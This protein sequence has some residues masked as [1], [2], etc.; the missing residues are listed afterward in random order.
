MI[1]V[2]GLTRKYGS[3]VAVDDISFICKPGTVTGFLGPNGAGKTTTMRVMVGLTPATAGEVTIGGLHF[4]DIPNPGRHVGRPPRRLGPA[5]RPH[6]PRGA[7]PRRQ[8][9]GPADVAGRR[10]ARPGLAR[11]H[12]GQ[13]PGPQLLPRHAAAARHR[14]RP[15]RRPVGAD[16]RR[17]R[18]RPRPGRHPLD[19]RPPQGLLRPRRHRAALQPPAQRGRADRRRDAADRPRQDR[20]PRHQGRAARGRRRD[21]RPGGG[22]GQRRPDRRPHGERGWPTRRSAWASGS[23]P[24]RST[25]AGSSVENRPSCSPTCAR[26]RAVS[27]TSSSSSPPTPSATTSS[28]RPP[29]Q[30]PRCDH[31]RCAHDPRRQPDRPGAVQPA[32]PGRA[33]QD[34]RHPG[35]PLA[36]DLDRGVHRAGAGHPAVGGARPGPDGHASTTSRAARTSR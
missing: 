34:V 12:R 29:R 8:D 36:A 22:R 21:R 4:H 27:R 2:E 24:C 14:P 23:T 30:E 18:Q 25:S 32:G 28:T 20:R 7:H 31:H 16:P 13:A 5:R 33:A 9:H 35:R 11:R 17:A 10:D 26:S 3:F 1:K 6:R 19:A 15:A